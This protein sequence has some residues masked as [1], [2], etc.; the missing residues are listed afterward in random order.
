MR[1]AIDLADMTAAQLKRAEEKAHAESMRQV[2][3]MIEAGRGRERFTDVVGKTD[4]LSVAYLAAAEHASNVSAEIRRRMEYG[5]TLKPIKRRDNPMQPEIEIDG[6]TVELTDT[7]HGELRRFDTE[8][9]VYPGDVD[10]GWF[11]Y[12]REGKSSA[13]VIKKVAWP[14]GPLRKWPKRGRL[15][16][17][18]FKTKK[19]ALTV[20]DQLAEICAPKVKSNPLKGSN[21]A[22]KKP[23]PAQVAAR[24]RFAEMARAG[25]FAKNPAKRKAKPVTRVSQATGAPP[26]KRLVKRR[27]KTATAPKGFFANPAARENQLFAVKLNAGNDRNGNPR[28]GWVVC[29]IL[30]AIDARA[31]GFVDEEY[32]GSSALSR[33]YGDMPSIGV[34]DVSPRDYAHMKKQGPVWIN[35]GRYQL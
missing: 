12:G 3:A 20:A 6:V 2:D 10:P 24:K 16:Q 5:G 22:T 33:A 25:V 23:T 9:M 29:E 19:Q 17:P 34:F 30:D 8:F 13:G 26:T 35:T 1:T 14:T 4:P 21:V 7:R 18:G 15:V 11:V 28:R 31:I 27:K 32:G